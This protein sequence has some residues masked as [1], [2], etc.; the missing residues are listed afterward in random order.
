MSLPQIINPNPVVIPEVPAVPE[1]HYDESYVVGLLLSTLTQWDQRLEV[2]LRPYNYTDEALYPGSGSDTV[3]VVSDIW[4]EASRVP[5]FAQ[6]MGGICQVT[7]LMMREK[8]LLALH[9][10]TPEEEAE[11]ADTRT[12]LGIT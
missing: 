9:E 8:Y 7:S 3:F 5:A 6:V 4:V 2:T 11:L 10:R 1:Y 12:A